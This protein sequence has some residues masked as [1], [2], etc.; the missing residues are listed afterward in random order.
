MRRLV[1]TRFSPTKLFVFGL[2]VVMAMLMASPA[3]WTTHSAGNMGRGKVGSEQDSDAPKS[4]R[5]ANLDVRVNGT[6]KLAELARAGSPA[7]AKRGKAQSLAIEKGLSSLNAVISGAKARLSPLTGAVE[8]LRSAGALTGPAQ[9][10][11]GNDIVREFFEANRGLYG[12]SDRDIA[13]LHF[14]GCLLYTSPSPR[15]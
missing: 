11:S 10:R 4:R 13:D 2:F 8:V 15:D 9:G 6:G 5:I 12:L 3:L 14:M 1:K 7:I